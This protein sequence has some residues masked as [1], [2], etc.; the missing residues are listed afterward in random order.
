[1]ETRKIKYSL[2]FLLMLLN[3]GCIK[4]NADELIETQ[5]G[6]VNGQF[7]GSSNELFPLKVN[8]SWQ[9]LVVSYDTMGKM[10]D[11][12]LQTI[13]ITKQVVLTKTKDTFYNLDGFYFKN[14]NNNTVLGLDTGY[15]TIERIKVGLSRQDYLG[16]VVAYEIDAV[17]FNF[18]VTYSYLAEVGLYTKYGRTCYL[19]RHF[20]EN[21]NNEL[22]REVEEYFQP[23]IGIVA[24]DIWKRKNQNSATSSFYLESRTELFGYRLN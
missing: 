4:K 6:R 5:N 19:T 21:E 1:M 9:Y 13:R 17:N 10:T 22:I 16:S 7:V 2:L 3:I 18:Y 8:N 24:R 12:V 23:G 15:R 11:S 20:I 14:H